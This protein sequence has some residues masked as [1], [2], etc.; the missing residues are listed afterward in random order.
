MPSGFE[1]IL[2]YEDTAVPHPRTPLRRPP[3]PSP[4]CQ[5]Q[6]VILNRHS[7]HIRQ[8]PIAAR[9]CG[10]V[11]RDRRPV[12]PPPIVQMLLANFDPHSK[13]DLEILQDPRYTVGCFLHEVGHESQQQAHPHSLKTTVS[14]DKSHHVRSSRS[15]L[16]GSA[17]SGRANDDPQSRLSGKAFVS[18]FFVEEDPDPDTA[19]VR[20]GIQDAVEIAPCDK[21]E[22]HDSDGEVQVEQAFCAEGERRP[23]R[24]IR[25][26]PAPAPATFFIFSD[27]SI[28][29]AGLYRLEFRLMNWG[30]VEDTGQSMP[31][32][33]EAWSDPFRVYTAKDFPGMLDSSRLAEGL[34]EL[35][36][37]ELKTRGKGKGKGRRR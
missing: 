30:C 24:K 2:N 22:G 1:R 18:P 10:A 3:S 29:V 33:A 15:L 6:P 28:Q 32:L 9:A 35:G 31:V 23:N 21:G 16:G 4:L 19:P 13:A 5:R 37:G 20:L 17:N 7:L 27:L 25:Q 11:D 36:F 14:T 26:A 34:K 8:Q 12:D